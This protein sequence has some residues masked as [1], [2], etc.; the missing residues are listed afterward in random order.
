MAN[1]IK[2]EGKIHKESNLNLN[3]HELGFYYSNR[4]RAT[5]AA[6]ITPGVLQP[7]HLKEISFRDYEGR[8]VIGE[9]RT[10]IDCSLGLS[11]MKVGVITFLIPGLGTCL[12]SMK[13][14]QTKTRFSMGSALTTTAW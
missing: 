1:M 12:L 9:Q 2:R 13:T 3:P 7:S 5:I 10:V 8:E 11:S 4:C 14:L 6:T